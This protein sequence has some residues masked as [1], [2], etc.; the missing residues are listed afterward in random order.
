MSGSERLRVHLRGDE[1]QQ[2]RAAK[3]RIVISRSTRQAI[4]QEGTHAQVGRCARAGI[5]TDGDAVSRIHA[6]RHV[7]AMHHAPRRRVERMIA[8]RVRGHVEVGAAAPPAPRRARCTAAAGVQSS[9]SRCGCAWARPAATSRRLERH[10]ASGIERDRSAEERRTGRRAERRDVHV[11]EV[12]RVEHRAA[13]VRPAD[14]APRGRPRCRCDARDSRA[15]R[16]RRSAAALAVMVRSPMRILHTSRTSR[17]PKLSGNSTAN[18]SARNRSARS[19]RRSA[20]SSC[21]RGASSAGR[22]NRA[23]R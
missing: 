13:A 15:R 6:V 3:R 2:R 10:A 20:S 12:D 23:A 5:G 14:D 17:E 16:A 22:R 8:A 19:A 9:R 21:G 4:A 11:V 1:Q 18:P 7:D